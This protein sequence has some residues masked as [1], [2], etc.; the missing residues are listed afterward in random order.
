MVAGDL[1]ATA[2]GAEEWA[3]RLAAALPTADMP[4]AA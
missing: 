2:A 3:T 1:I 4:T